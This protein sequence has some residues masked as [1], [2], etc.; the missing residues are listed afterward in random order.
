M[1]VFDDAHLLGSQEY[2][3]DK[4]H[5]SLLPAI[6]E[7]TL[8]GVSLSKANID[9]VAISEG[10]GSYTGLRIGASIAKGLCY[11]LELPL[12]ALNTLEVMAAEV[13]VFNKHKALLCPMIDARRMEVYACVISA[14]GK[15]VEDTAPHIIDEMSFSSFLKEKEVW[16]FGNGSD[17]CKDVFG[18]NKNAVFVS[19]IVPSAKSMGELAHQQFQS[20][21][22]RDLAY[23]EPFYL[24]E[25][26][27]TKPKASG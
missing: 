17:K 22:F 15:V 20:G 5:S 8:E 9:A 11:S 26:R 12:I 7:T 3:I 21:S 25:F 18:A 24:K 10:P 6:I 4:S 19:G 13:N 14:E 23:F 1:A 2:R 27:A 16:F